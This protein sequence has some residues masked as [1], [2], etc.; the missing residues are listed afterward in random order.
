MILKAEVTKFARTLDVDPNTIERDYVISWFLSGIYADA[1]L[2]EALVFKGGTALRKVYFPNYRFSEDLDFTVAISSE[3]LTKEILYERLQNVARSVSALSGISFSLVSFE[4]TRDV[5]GEEAFASKVAYVGPMQNRSSSPPRIKLDITFYEDVI[6]PTNKLS[7]IHGYSDEYMCAREIRVY[8]LE[9]IVAEKLR[10]ILQ[11][12]RPRDI[13]DLWSLLC[14]NTHE[15]N[16][17]ELVRGFY[18]KCEHKKVAFTGINDFFTPERLDSHANA[19]E[20]TLCHQLAELP[21]FKDVINDLKT[22]IVEL[23]DL[24]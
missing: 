16:L 19:W 11:R 1:V 10:S 21:N 17:C 6:F 15:I 13:Y 4:R 18:K 24:K 9:E 22:K 2:A 8:A 12:N 3:Q 7:L 5:L 14:K 20:K 23:F